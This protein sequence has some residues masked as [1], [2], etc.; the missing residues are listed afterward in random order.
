[1][2]NSFKI[3]FI[4]FL[5]S[6]LSWA[7]TKPIQPDQATGQDVRAADLAVSDV[8]T[9]SANQTGTSKSSF[10][11]S[12]GFSKEVRKNDDGTIT[13][14]LSFNPSYHFADAVVRSGEI[15]INW[16]LGWRLDSTKQAFVS[17]KKFSRNA[18]TLCGDL[19]IQLISAKP[20]I[21]NPPVFKIVEDNMQLSLANDEKTT[22][23]GIRTIEWLNGFDTKS[24]R[25]DD[26]K[27][28]NFSKEG[29]NRNGIAFTALGKDLIYDNQCGKGKK[30]ITAGT[31]TITKQDTKTVFRFGD[32]QCD[33]SFTITQGNVTLTIN[34]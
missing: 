27:K 18:D 17:F 28:I 19:K 25:N 5:F 20:T 30:K 29:I 13:T 16:Q 31:I 1:M 3:F 10:A 33:N 32:G 8:F 2:I 12:L 9:F 14:I 34:Q 15:I 11:D 6:V 21:D 7:C 4:L 23:N 22:W 26:V 24:N